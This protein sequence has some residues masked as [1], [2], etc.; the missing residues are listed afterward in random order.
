V[1]GSVYSKDDLDHYTHVNGYLQELPQAGEIQVYC[2]VSALDT[3][4]FSLPERD[5]LA[6]SNPKDSFITTSMSFLIKHSSS[7][8]V[9]LTLFDLGLRKD[10][11]SY[12]PALQPH[13]ET[14][15]PFTVDRE[16]KDCLL[17]GG[18]SPE[19]IEVRSLGRH[20][21]ISSLN[22][23]LLDRNSKPRSLGPH[24]ASFSLQERNTFCRRRIYVSAQARQ[25]SVWRRSL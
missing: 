13:L 8:G 12:L 7:S 5:F 19:D 17:D 15:R 23:L 24:W 1:T 16:A 18:I 25:T 3:G 2:T 14:R 20:C 10:L 6:C 11:S 4:L 21:P 9:N 22:A